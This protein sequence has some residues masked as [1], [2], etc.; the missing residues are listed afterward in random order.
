M[1]RILVSVSRNRKE[2]TKSFL[3]KQLN[4]DVNTPLHLCTGMGVLPQYEKI[5]TDS[6]A[7]TP[8]VRPEIL[9]H[10][11]DDVIIRE[12]G[13]IERVLKEFQD[14]E[15]GLVGFGGA[16]QHGSD[17]IYKKPYHISQLGRSL[18]FSNTDDALSHGSV[19]KA[20]RDVAVLD[21]FCLI[22]RMEL[23]EKMEGWQPEVWPFHH[24]YDYR[25]CLEARRHGYRIRL[26]GVRCLHQGGMTATRSEYQE[27]CRSTR[28]GSDAVMHEEGHKMI[29]QEYGDV[30][31]W[32]SQ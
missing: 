25:I 6:L 1:K 19:C 27:W 32:K 22:A 2:S 21:G 11:H 20:A 9:A 18:Y 3:R 23:L 7:A 5:F 10:L 4:L 17:D 30:L 12:D 26:V 14:P 28:W 8:S 15:V 31:P 29:Y 16:L 13:W 24:V